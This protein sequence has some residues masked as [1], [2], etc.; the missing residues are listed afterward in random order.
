MRTFPGKFA[1]VPRDPNESHRVA[2]N[3]EL[4]FDLATVVAIAAAAAGLHHA[5]AGSHV[6]EG[7]AGFG[8]AFFAIWW[9]WM[10]YTWF[11]SAYDNRTSAF[12]LLTLLVIFGALV[13]AAGIPAIFKSEPFLLGLVGYLVMRM[14][15]ILLWL[16][17]A[18]GDPA[19]RLCAIRYAKG[20]AVAQLYWIALIT[21]VAPAS[22]WFPVLFLLGAAI[23]LAVPPF[24]E[25]SRQT[26]WHRHHII[27]RY[28][29]LNIIVLGECMLAVVVALR[30]ADGDL[31]IVNPLVYTAVSGAITTFC[32]WWVYF[33]DDEHLGR[34]TNDRAFVWGYG[35]IVVFAAGAATGAGYSVLVDV[36]AG[37][38]EATL[39]T[40]YLAVGIPIAL[41]LFGLWFVRDRF[42]LVG[43]WKWLLPAGAVVILAVGALAPASLELMTLVLVLTAVARSRAATVLHTHA[44]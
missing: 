3:L 37:E 5:I 16:M 19:N 42:C 2:T 1:L 21:L 39:R 31:T 7:I 22:A 36:L 35:H 29:L 24:A 15:M 13:M 6:A 26:V 27:E 8:F 4:L 18:L 41:Y 28:G 11:A 17:A 38:S 12:R 32:L 43:F 9:A 30:A 25:R 10:N 23:E 20:I 40:G 44:P 14:G 33:T 34:D